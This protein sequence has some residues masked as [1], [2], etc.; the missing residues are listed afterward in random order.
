MVTS[1]SNPGES[2]L[3]HSQS[4]WFSWAGCGVLLP[5]FAAMWGETCWRMKQKEEAK[6]REAK[7]KSKSQDLEIFLEHLDLEMPKVTS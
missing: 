1:P 3:P 6:K 4:T 7:M 2:L 5:I